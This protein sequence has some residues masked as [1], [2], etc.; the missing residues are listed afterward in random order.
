MFKKA[1][2]M[3]EVGYEGPIH[4]WFKVDDGEEAAAE[5]VKKGV[6]VD[7]VTKAE[8]PGF[9]PP[10][11]E[12][13]FNEADVGIRVLSRHPGLAGFRQVHWRKVKSDTKG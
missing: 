2:E 5:A 9:I 1:V 3:A 12:A 6:R 8:L 10:F 11:K 13:F 4:A 7:F